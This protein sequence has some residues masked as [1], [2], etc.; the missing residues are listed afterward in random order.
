MANGVTLAAPATAMITPATGEK[1]RNKPPANCE[2]RTS[3]TNGRFILP[4]IP[5]WHVAAV[6]HVSASRCDAVPRVQKPGF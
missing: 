5:G 1:L 6:N 2:G 4:A 3:D